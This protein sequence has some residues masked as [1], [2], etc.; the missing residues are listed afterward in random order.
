MDINNGGP[1]QLP[2]IAIGWNA[3]AQIVE[4]QFDPAHFKTW[5]FVIALLDMAKLQ[6]ENNRRLAQL[7]AMQQQSQDEAIRKALAASR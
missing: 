1:K 2:A 6:A 7:R 4:I 5:D 3:E